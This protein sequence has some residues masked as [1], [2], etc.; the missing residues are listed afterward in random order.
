M[1]IVLGKYLT[2]NNIHSFFP[3]EFFKPYMAKAEKCVELANS[4]D[5]DE[6]AL[7]ILKFIYLGQNIFDF[8]NFADVNFVFCAFGV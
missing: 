5:A 7:W 8:W 2:T 3:L 1:P 6:V 4:V